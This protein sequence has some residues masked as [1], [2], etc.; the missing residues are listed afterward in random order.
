MEPA[1]SV[2]VPVFDEIE[3]LPAFNDELLAALDGLETPHEVVYVDDGSTDGS[4]A[5]LTDW[6]EADPR[7]RVVVLRRN[8]GKSAALAAGFDAAR[9]P[10]LAMMDAD[11][12]DVPAELGGLVAHLEATSSDLVGGWRRDRHDRAIKRSSSR[13]YN[14]VTRLL[15]GLELNDLNTGFKVLRREVAREL[16]LYGE[17]HRYLPVLAHDLGFAVTEVPV[18][19]RPRQAGRS[20]YL[21]VLRF[22]KTLLDLLTVLFLTRF[23]DRPL[24]LFGGVGAVLAGIGTTI[25]AY[26]SILRLVLDRGIGQRP[27]LQLGVLMVLVGVQLIGT[28]FIGDVLRHGHAA[29]RRPYRVRQQSWAATDRDRTTGAAG[30]PTGPGVPAPHTP[31]GG[32]GTPSADR[33]APPE[34]RQADGVAAATP[35]A[36]DADAAAA[37]P[38]AADPDQTRP[39][40][41]RADDDT[42]GGA[43]RQRRNAPAAQPRRP[44][45]GR[46]DLPAGSRRRR[47]G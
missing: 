24:Y 35:S 14:R 17:L 47:R 12:Q 31:A 29:E 26:L 40:P 45:P 38:A 32:T 22:P 4:T 8:F 41:D 7:I 42:R 36:T 11:G 13:L 27:L 33:A 37:S 23:G 3:A 30:P 25:L 6:A 15:T 10:V 5:L 46:P 16:P 1:L 18:R 2:V 34:G 20:K 9:A 21:S 39:A 19:H 28:G 43:R 44:R